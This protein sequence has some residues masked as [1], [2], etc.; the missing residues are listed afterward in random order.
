MSLA[1]LIGVALAGDLVHFK[2]KDN[3]PEG[4]V[5]ITQK[6]NRDITSFT[7]FNPNGT[8]N[9]VEIDSPSSPTP[10]HVTY[11]H[12]G[13]DCKVTDELVCDEESIVIHDLPEIEAISISTPGHLSLFNAFGFLYHVDILLNVSARTQRKGKLKERDLIKAYNSLSSLDSYWQMPI[14]QTDP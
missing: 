10:G 4:L 5:S 3:H 11:I 8:Y 14:S 9:T 12:L 6:E 1:L 2:E 7:Y 13:F